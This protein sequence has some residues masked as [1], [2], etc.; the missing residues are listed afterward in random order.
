MV[1]SLIN[2]RLKSTSESNEL[3]KVLEDVQNL[4]VASKKGRGSSKEGALCNV[5]GYWDSESG[6]MTFHILKEDGVP[7]VKMR[8]T[9][10]PSEDGFI[11]KDNWNVTAQIPFPQSAQIVIALTAYKG[12]KVALFLGKPSRENLSVTMFPRSSS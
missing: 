4:I 5:A 10:P 12:R 2:D 11:G 1:D 7:V 3:N 6:G 8:P 9:E